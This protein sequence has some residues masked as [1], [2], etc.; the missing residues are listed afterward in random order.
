MPYYSFDPADFGD[1]EFG[2]DDYQSGGQR[3]TY[4]PAEISSNVRRSD[5]LARDICDVLIAKGFSSAVCSY[6][7]GYDEGFAR[8]DSAIVNGVQFDLSETCELLKSTDIV[9]AIKASVDTSNYPDE[10]RKQFNERSSEAHIAE[11]L[12]EFAFFVAAELLGDGFGT[13][14]YELK[15]RFRID[16]ES[17]HVTDLKELD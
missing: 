1:E 10:F 9:D 17:G 6:D 4:E 13:G 5:S 16:L 14:E 12:E 15:G 2:G 11:G 3:H 8:F 7:G